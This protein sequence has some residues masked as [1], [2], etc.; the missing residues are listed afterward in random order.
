MRVVAWLLLG[1][2]LA[3]EAFDDLNELGGVLHRLNGD[4]KP[5]LAISLRQVLA[6][7]GFRPKRGVSS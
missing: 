4:G 2:A 7:P 5:G 3:L 1:I 6:M